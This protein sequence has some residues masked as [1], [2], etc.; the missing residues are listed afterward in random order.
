[1][2][3]KIPKHKR[4]KGLIPE[5]AVIAQPQKDNIPVF[6]FKYVSENHCLL[7]DWHGNELIELIEAFKIM[8]SLSWNQVLTHSGLRYKKIDKLARPLPRTVSPDVAICEFRICQKKRVLGYRMGNI[9]RVIWFDRN[10]EIC[11]IG[12]NRK[13]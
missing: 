7:S 12:K 1:M 4:E 9:F 13:A 3:I 5:A 10:H 6:S 8:E 2:N 11:P